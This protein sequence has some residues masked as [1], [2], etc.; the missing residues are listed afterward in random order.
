M[1]TRVRQCGRGRQRES[2]RELSLMLL[3]LK[4]E[5]G[6]LGPG[7]WWLLEAGKAGARILLWHLQEY[8]PALFTLVCCNSFQTSDIENCKVINLHFKPLSLW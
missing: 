7:L 4:M 8:S 6:A 1:I 2:Q 5:E 3:T